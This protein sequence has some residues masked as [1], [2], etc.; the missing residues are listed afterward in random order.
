MTSYLYKSIADIV[1]MSEKNNIP[2]WEVVQRAENEKTEMAIEEIRKIVKSRLD[3]FRQSVK[4]G[5][6]DTSATA[7][8]MSGGQAHILKESK[9][10]LLSDLSYR[11]MV[12]AIAVSEANAKM[13]RVVACP[14]AGSCGILPGCFTA[15][16]E[17]KQVSEES[18]INGLLAAAGIGNV[19]TNNATVAGAVGGCQAECGAASAM[20]AAGIVTILGGSAKQVANAAALAMKNVLG[21]VCDPVA[22]LVEV[23]CVKRN[24][25]HALH[26]LTAA[27]MSLQG[28]VSAI[29]ADEV[30]QVMWE[31]GTALPCSLRET[32][33]GGLATSPTGLAIAKKVE[34]L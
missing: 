14:T 27:E 26:S 3:I 1:A 6:A 29:P 13:F 5:I 21:L 15:L 11:A 9:S 8:G 34:N 24:G 17:I 31:V 28:L 2:F 20:A 19:I 22:G 33:Q 16:E 30:I 7:S 10:L 12:N 18:L 23:P 25:F 4:E 32:S